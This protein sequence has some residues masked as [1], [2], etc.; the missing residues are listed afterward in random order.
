[1]TAQSSDEILLFGGLLVAGA[2]IGLLKIVRARAQRIQRPALAS[3]LALRKGVVVGIVGGG[4]KTSLLFALAREIVGLDPTTRIVCTTTTKMFLPLVPGDCDY[5]VSHTDI[6]SS[7]EQ[8]E[9]IFD[10]AHGA[11]PTVML[12]GGMLPD[13]GRKRKIK[14]VGTDLPAQL[15]ASG[16][17]DVVLVEADGS[18]RLPFKAPDKHEPALPLRATHVIAVA[19]VDCLG[20]ELAEESVCRASIVSE[21]T[22]IPMGGI[23]TPACVATVLSSRAIWR[24][25]ESAT[26]FV[27]CI[28]KVD[29]EQ[30]LAA[31]TEVAQLIHDH[32][33]GVA[34]VITGEVAGVRGTVMGS[35]IPIR[36]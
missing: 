22:G 18:R 23:V 4:G 28:N 6:R 29:T 26:R 24:V 8:L 17:C 19:G 15:V 3:I 31:A 36:V 14:G 12:I 16:A 21:L 2:S 5:L 30:Q 10:G 34:V 9:K 32:A 13:T 7:T 35:S 20:T 1:M 27:A 25:E 33:E 11:T